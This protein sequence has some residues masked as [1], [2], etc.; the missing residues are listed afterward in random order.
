ML[1]GQFFLNALSPSWDEEL[2]I[3]Q[4]A[5]SCAPQRAVTALKQETAELEVP[6]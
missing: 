5:A 1:P 2:I 6:S 3:R 4:F